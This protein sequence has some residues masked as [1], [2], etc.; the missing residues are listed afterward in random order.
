MFL[1]GGAG[2]VQEVFHAT[3]THSHQSHSEPTPM[4]LVNREHW[5]GTL[6]VRPLLQTLVVGHPI[7]L[8]I[9]PVE[10]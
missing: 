7:A 5:T 1:P 8:R 10:T 6:P 4:M 9:A 2:T 3:T